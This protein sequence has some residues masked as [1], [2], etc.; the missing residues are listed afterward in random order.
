MERL[1]DGFSRS[2]W[3]SLAV[4]ALRIGWPA[5]LREAQKRL[6]PSAFK[7]T[8]ICGVFEDVLPAPADFAEVVG[9]VDRLD[10]VRLCGRD[11][12]HGRGWTERF[13]ELED[14]AVHEAR[15]DPNS[16]RRR[17]RERGVPWFL[18]PRSLNCVWTWLELDPQESGSREVDATEWTGVP[19]AMADMHTQEG[20]ERG[21]F[22]TVLSGTY[23]QHARLAE[24]IAVEGWAGVRGRA[25]E[26]GTL[27]PTEWLF[28]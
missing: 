1:L 25:H 26:G 10:L 28:P 15:A 23:R 27:E 8:L 7:S 9:E 11:T 12:H 4:K 2:L 3:T 19:A 17:A 20:R 14:E 6:A 5:G 18:P 16:I 22:V 24:M 13:C 21:T